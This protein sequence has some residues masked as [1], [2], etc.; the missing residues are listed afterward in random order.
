V[1]YSSVAPP[2]SR[3]RARSGKSGE[4]RVQIA[5]RV[6]KMPLGWTLVQPHALFPF[7][8]LPLFRPR[9]QTFHLPLDRLL[10]LGAVLVRYLYSIARAY[11]RFVHHVTIGR[12]FYKSSRSVEN[13]ADS[14]IAFTTYIVTHAR[15]RARA[16][17]QRERERHIDFSGFAGRD[18]IPCP[19]HPR[20]KP[21]NSPSRNQ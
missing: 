17:Q 1:F 9:E 12:K 11:S 14:L 8:R 15:A 7:R 18:L 19:C 16:Q 21:I 13:R 2:V 20:K 10:K 5:K 4:T 3:A 6:A